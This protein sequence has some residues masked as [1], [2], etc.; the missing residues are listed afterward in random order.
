MNIKRRPPR[1]PQDVDPW[2]RAQGDDLYSIAGTVLTWTPVLSDAA[3]GGNLA[4]L[5]SS[6]GY[7]TQKNREY[8]LS[9]TILNIDTSGMTGGNAL[10]I[11]GI[12]ETCHASI[13]ATGSVDL[14]RFSFSG[15]YVNP[16]IIAGTNYIVLNETI[17]NSTDSLIVVS[18]VDGATSD[19]TQLTIT[20]F[21]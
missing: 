16:R 9:A 2:R 17:T 20:Y 15:E 4:S 14:D 6:L 3:S 21:T 5:G 8:T 19:I 18:N 13:G 1:V 10:Y 12:P 7:Y 11:Q